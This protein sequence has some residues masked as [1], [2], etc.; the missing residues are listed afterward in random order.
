[1][2]GAE[3]AAR[4]RRGEGGRADIPL[5]AVTADSATSGVETGS[6]GFDGIITKPIDPRQLQ[7]TLIGA[8]LRRSGRQPPNTGPSDSDSA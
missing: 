8:I 4:I 5:L 1:M 7:S 6:D 3:I 2:D